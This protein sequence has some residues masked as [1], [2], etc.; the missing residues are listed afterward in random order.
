[1]KHL[2][3]WQAAEGVFSGALLASRGQQGLPGA[4]RGQQGLQGAGGHS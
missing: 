2:E 3:L 1:M 4:S